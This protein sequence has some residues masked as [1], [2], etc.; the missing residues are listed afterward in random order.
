MTRAAALAVAVAVALDPYV[1]LAQ[2]PPQGAYG[3]AGVAVSEVYQENL[4]ATPT[5]RGPAATD[6]ITRYG[7]I[8]EAGYRSEQLTFAARYEADAER[9]E[10][11]PELN[12][13][14]ARQDAFGELIYRPSRRAIYGLT[15]SFAETYSPMELSTA[16]SFVLGRVHADRVTLRPTLEYRWNPMLGFKAD[17]EAARE[18]LAGA[19][20]AIIQVP[21]VRLERSTN[22]RLTFRVD[23]RV[24]DFSTTDDREFSQAITAGVQRTF[25]RGVSLEFDAGPRLSTGPVRPEVA[26]R[27]RH[28]GRRGEWSIDY[29]ETDTNVLGQVGIQQVRRVRFGTMLNAGRHVSISAA[30]SLVRDAR[31]NLHTTSEVVEFEM[32]ARASRAVSIVVSGQGGRQIGNLSSVTETVP[33]YTV[34][35]SLR[36]AY[37]GEPRID[38]GDREG[39]RNAGDRA[40][41]RPTRAVD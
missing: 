15:G 1:S 35:T 21:H 22:R 33:Y 31:Y 18:A 7:P 29:A 9:F 24:R 37:P 5:S 34:M 17:Y 3:S 26:A 32:V 4:F 19:P 30:P 12:R 25:G 11:H 13:T 6:L 27:L 36:I 41:P 14:L 28:S 16:D 38:P 23:Y 2:T 20:S 39:D 8:G 10:R 40:R